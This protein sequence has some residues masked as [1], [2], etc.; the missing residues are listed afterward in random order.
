[1]M[2]RGS[3][4]YVKRKFPG[5]GKVY[6]SLGTKSAARARQLEGMLISLHSQGRLDV[7][8]AFVDGQLEIER[9]AEAYETGRLHELAAA[10]K[11]R[12]V[13]LRDAID[14]ALR[15]KA[16]DVKKS[17]LQRYTEGL[18]HFSRFC[19]SGATVH[20]SL[21][22]E[23]VQEFKG[24]RLDEGA[25]EETVNNDLGAV[26]V[27]AT[28]CIQKG[29][30]TKR[31]EVKRFRTKIRIRYLEPDELTVYMA[32]LRSSFR[33]LF[34]LLVGSGVRLGEGES[35]RVCDLRFGKHEARALIED[36]KSPSG[37][38]P[39]FV[40]AWAA[41]ALRARIAEYGLSGTDLIF[42]FKRKT[43][44][45]EHARACKI[46]GIVE[47]TIHDHR[48]TAAVSLARAGMPLHLLQRQ[49]GH[50]NITMTMRYA[51][52]HPDYGDVSRYFDRVAR[53]FGLS[54][55]GAGSSLGSSPI[56]ASGGVNV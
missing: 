56:G 22:M 10:L 48:H 13:P 7:V 15:A 49:L 47:Y 27:L 16:A 4:W 18:T 17:T 39:V 45:Q 21:A 28:Y 31:P 2:K 37:V 26:S 30:L 24:F 40:P 46:A 43:V 14:G 1:M 41:Q 8:R 11:H 36:S 51:Q 29:W 19:G 9:L 54:S 6:K 34:Q 44:Q 12:T 25:A 38:R 33:P 20:E 3:V 23:R 5:I 32:A 50:A 52:F 53:T 55:T 35:L 42:S